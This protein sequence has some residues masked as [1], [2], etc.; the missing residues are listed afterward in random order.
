MPKISR[1]GEEGRKKFLARDNCKAQEIPNGP[2]LLT[3]PLPEEKNL[4]KE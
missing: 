2:V 3:R 4:C 1:N